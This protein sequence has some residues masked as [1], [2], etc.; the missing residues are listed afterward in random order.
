MK[1]KI[2]IMDVQPRNLQQLRD[3]IVSKG[4]LK[5]KLGPTWY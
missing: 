3:A 5:T 4:S 2:H 1:G